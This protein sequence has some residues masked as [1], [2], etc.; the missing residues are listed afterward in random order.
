MSTGFAGTSPL[1]SRLVD[2][3]RRETRAYPVNEEARLRG[4][5]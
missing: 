3:S 1:A 4:L 2:G 5:S